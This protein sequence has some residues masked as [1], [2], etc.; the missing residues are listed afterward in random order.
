VTKPPNVVV[1]VLDCL[2]ARALPRAAPDP[3]LPFFGELRRDSVV[4]PNCASVSHWTVPSHASLLTGAYPWQ[5]GLFHGGQAVLA[6][7]MPRLA[8]L[9]RRTGY[10]TASFAANGL[11][12]PGLGWLDGF[13][14][15]AW[16]SSAYRR[17][18]RSDRPPHRW[19]DPVGATPVARDSDRWAALTYWGVVGLE[20]F[21][22]VLDRIARVEHRVRGESD[23]S[24]PV[25][26]PWIERDLGRWLRARDADRPV[27]AF[28]NL[29]DAHEPYLL[30][31][32]DG[33][34]PS[35]LA[36]LGRLRQDHH[37]WIAGRWEPTPREQE[38]LE[39][40]YRASVRV[41]DDRVRRVVGALRAA[42]RWDDTLFVLT[43]D[44]G[45]SFDASAGLYHMTGLSEDLLRVPLWVRFPHGA[46]G[47]SEGV[48]WTSQIDVARTAADAAGSELPGP[49]VPL[50]ELR[51]RAREE[52]VFALGDGPTFGE[53]QGHLRTGGSP[54]VDPR[55]VAG[56][57]GA[58][59]GVHHLGEP[60]TRFYR[61]GAD[62]GLATPVDDPGTAEATRLGERLRSLADHLER[63]GPDP[64]PGEERLRAWGYID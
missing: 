34:G 59:K 60:A 5:H 28:L 12:Q 19:T 53:S 50:E 10:Q 11:I 46:F 49:G 48:G 30:D 6:P 35:V 20:R 8:S 56:Y 22:W 29:M 43:S 33:I 42:H 17:S 18:S 26:A 39:I 54:R 4:F 14:Y 23:R 31:R 13:D 63:R 40:L 2:R 37:G 57:S 36:E 44:H 24:R 25:L 21:P 61:V 27:F 16:G 15:A 32:E 47:G 41:L 7:E 45:Q 9:L 51:L 38:L 62:A 3:A 1:V 55:G 64:P 52:P 58:W